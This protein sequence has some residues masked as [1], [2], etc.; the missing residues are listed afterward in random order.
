MLIDKAKSL[1]PLKWRSQ[2]HWFELKNGDLHVVESKIISLP[3]YV[4]I[5]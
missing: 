5:R 3:L 4:C 2:E 1:G